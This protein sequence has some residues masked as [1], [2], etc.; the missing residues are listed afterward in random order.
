M[1]PTEYPVCRRAWS[2]DV[3]RD[4]QWLEVLGWGEYADWVVRG[5]GAVWE[6][7]TAVGA[8]MSLER[9]AGLRYSIDDIRKLATPA[10]IMQPAA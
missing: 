7:Q 8:G 2:L 4:D 3:L 1:A 5:I 10:P 9:L 6:R